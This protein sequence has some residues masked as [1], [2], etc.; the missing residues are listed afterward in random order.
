MKKKSTWEQSVKLAY[1]L[2]Q[3]ALQDLPPHEVAQ[4]CA[5]KLITGDA[6]RY[7]E[8]PFLN[9]R[10]RVILPEG[11]VRGEGDDDPTLVVK[12]LILHYLTHAQGVQLT[13][14]WVDFRQLPG[15][16]AY[17]P[18]FRGRV[19]GRLVRLFGQ[20]PGDLVTAAEPWGGRAVQL[21]D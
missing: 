2:A 15:G 3:K 9:R 18:V 4:R 7:L 5:V 21:A 10:Y 14:R 8:V 6:E 1:Q 16:V 12:V 19:I 20:R 13:R 17:Y 11:E